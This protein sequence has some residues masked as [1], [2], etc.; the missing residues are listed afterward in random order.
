MLDRKLTWSPHIST[1]HSKA[2]RKMDLMKKLAG[3][4]WWAHMEYASNTWSSAART[5]LDQLTKVQNAGLRIIT[6][7]MKTTPISEVER[8]AG[9]LSS[10]GRERKNSCAKAKRWRGFLHTHY[11]PSLKLPPNP[12]SRDKAQT[13][14]SKRFSRNTGSPIGTQ[15]TTG[16]ASKLWGL[17]SRNPNHH[18]RHL[19]HTSQGAPHRW[20]A[21]VTYPWS[22]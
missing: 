1:M 19:R 13:T 2:L 16:N 15:P 10:E 5:N 4:K 14:W 17:A 22:P 18:P 11:I 9:L 3:T 12:D 21:E 6:G 7:G 8:T 20:R